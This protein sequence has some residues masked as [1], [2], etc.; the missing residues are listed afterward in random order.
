MF[1]LRSDWTTLNAVEPRISQVGAYSML[2][3]E[4]I[5]K[6]RH[7]E[8]A[9]EAFRSTQEGGGV[10]ASIGDGDVCEG[11]IRG[12]DCRIGTVGRARQTVTVSR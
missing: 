10:D 2:R 9:D 7:T 4:R 1:P 5:C 11:L 12:S 8:K 3:G 6:G